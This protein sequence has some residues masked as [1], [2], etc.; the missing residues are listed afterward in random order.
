[1]PGPLQVAVIASEF[2]DEF[3]TTSPPPALQIVVLAVLAP[4]GRLLGRRA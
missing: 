4:I 3:R 2:R 1:V